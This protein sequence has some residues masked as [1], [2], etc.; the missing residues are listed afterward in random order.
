M[1]PAGLSTGPRARSKYDLKST[2]YDTVRAGHFAG[3]GGVKNAT[4]TAQFEPRP[5]GFLGP[6]QGTFEASF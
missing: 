4:K 2:P 5:P 3:I 1:R 6:G